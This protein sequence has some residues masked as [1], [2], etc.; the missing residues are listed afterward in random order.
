MAHARS[1]RHILR[2]ARLH[3]GPKRSERDDYGFYKCICIWKDL[4]SWVSHWRAAAAAAILAY[5]LSTVYEAGEFRDVVEALPPGATCDRVSITG[6]EDVTQYLEYYVVSSDD[7]AWMGLAGGAGT[8]RE[9]IAEAEH[10]GGVYILPRDVCLRVALRLNRVCVSVSVS[11]CLYVSVSVCVRTR[12][13]PAT[14]SIRGATIEAPACWLPARGF[15]SPRHLRA[16]A[17][18]VI[19]TAQLSSLA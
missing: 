6:P 17:R 1:S 5:A 11:V 16:A 4:M 15:P 9:R 12:A 19:C 2:R 8:M 13:L 14:G 3:P 7:R 18:C 10:Q